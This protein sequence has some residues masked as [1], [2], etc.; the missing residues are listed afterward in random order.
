MFKSIDADYSATVASPPAARSSPTRCS[1]PTAPPTART[2]GLR[3]ALRHPVH[4]RQPDAG[5]GRRR[6]AQAHPRDQPGPDRPQRRHHRQRRRRGHRR[7]PADA[8]AGRLPADPADV[9]DRRDDTPAPDRRQDPVLTTSRAT[10]SPTAPAA[11][12]TSRRSSPSSAS[13]TARSTTTARASSC[14]PR[15][16]ARC[17]AP[18]GRSCRCCRPRSTTPRP[19]RPSRT[20]MVFAHHPVDDPAETGRQPARRPQRGRAGREAAVGLPRGVR[21]GRGDGRLARA[22]RRRR[23]ASRAS[24]TR[25]CRPRARTRTARRTAAASRAGWTG[26]RQD[27]TAAQQWLTADVRA[28][29]QSITLERAG[30]AR[31]GRLRAARRLDRPAAG[32]ANGTRRRAAALPDVGPLE[33]LRRLGDRHRRRRRQGRRQGR[34]SSTRPPAS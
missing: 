30:G 34:A 2:T 16:T 31:G 33:R 1:P 7:S 13:R 24:R 12:A 11:R 23:T 32:V 27:A 22:D 17:A 4:G 18:T 28:F 25:C 15:P 21:Q 26:R 8:R 29:A 20:S 9:D 6:R 14:S 19:T 10:T 3:H 5:E